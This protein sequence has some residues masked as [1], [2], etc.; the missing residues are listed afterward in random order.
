M[1]SILPAF[2]ITSPCAPFLSRTH[3]LHACFNKLRVWIFFALLFPFL[4]S[5]GDF[6]KLL[7]S[8]N[9]HRFYRAI[10]WKLPSDIIIGWAMK[11]ITSKLYSF[12]GICWSCL[13]KMFA[14]VFLKCLPLSCFLILKLLTECLLELVTEWHVSQQID[15]V[16]IVTR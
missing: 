10:C 4:A 7:K 14:E 8:R 13:H 1:L 5:L 9:Y 16:G 11:L 15:L 12:R 6:G 3:C 2:L